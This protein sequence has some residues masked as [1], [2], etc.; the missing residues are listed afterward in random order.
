MG[1]AGALPAGELDD[2]RALGEGDVADAEDGEDT[3]HGVAAGGEAAGTT[4]VCVSLLGPE[5]A[6]L[7]VTRV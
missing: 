6:A 4:G 3:A 1:R 2:A 5:R 7:L